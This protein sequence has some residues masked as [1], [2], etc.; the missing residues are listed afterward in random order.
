[1]AVIPRF[2]NLKHLSIIFN[3][4]DIIVDNQLIG[5]LHCLKRL[6]DLSIGG[7]KSFTS[8]GLVDLVQN[9]PEL[10]KLSLL[11]DHSNKYMKV[12][13]STYLRICGIYRNRNKKLVIYNSDTRTHLFGWEDEGVVKWEWDEP[14]A[15]LGQRENVRYFK[16]TAVF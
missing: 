16:K 1:M 10:E 12:M 4:V 3:E 14:F 5:N 13:E 9:L 6:R 2:T 8:N 7:T 15:T 11:I